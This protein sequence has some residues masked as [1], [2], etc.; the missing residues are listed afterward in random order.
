MT[1]I[2]EIQNVKH[3]FKFTHK[4]N[5][6]TI[7]LVYGDCYEIS[8]AQFYNHYTNNEDYSNFLIVLMVE[9]INKG[10]VC[11]VKKIIIGINCSYASTNSTTNI[12]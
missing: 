10:M 9:K 11:I 5:Y 4:A 8:S 7:Y 3:V 2:L 1:N 6:R 12:N